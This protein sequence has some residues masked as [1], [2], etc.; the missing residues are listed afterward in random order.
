M[1]SGM[2]KYYQIARCYRDEDLR[3]DRQPEFTQI[4]IEASF[5]NQADIM[6]L[7]EGMLRA[8]FSSVIQVEL[9]EF[10]S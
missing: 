6:S 10:Q 9:P 1:M 7:T 8:V 5:I 2:D 3:A 4:D